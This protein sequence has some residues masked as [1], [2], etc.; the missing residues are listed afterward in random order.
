MSGTINALGNS[1]PPVLIFSRVHYN[2]F[3]IKGAPH[4]T[5][6]VATPSGWISTEDFVNEFL[7]SSLTDVAP[8]E[9]TATSLTSVI[10]NTS[11]DAPS[12]S[13]SVAPTNNCYERPVTPPHQFIPPHVI[14]LVQTLKEMMIFER[15]EKGKALKY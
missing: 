3:M 5:L 9:T 7:A 4:G 6:D 14:S 10:T 8:S 13:S 11:L 1:I 12:T 2:D 15:A